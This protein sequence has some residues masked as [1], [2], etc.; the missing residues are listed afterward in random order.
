MD[1]ELSRG[2]ADEYS[3]GEGWQEGVELE[4]GDDRNGDEVDE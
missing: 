3:I 1:D 2:D 4:G